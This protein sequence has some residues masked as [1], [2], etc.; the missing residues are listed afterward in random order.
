MLSDLRM[1]VEALRRALGQPS[2]TG[3]VATAL[4]EVH[5]FWSD[6]P[7]ARAPLSYAP[8][9]AVIVSGRKIGFLEDKRI[10]Y[11]P[12]QYLAIGLPLYFECETSATAAEPLLGLFLSAEPK[13]LQRLADGMADCG[14]PCLPAEPRLG[15]EPLDAGPPLLEAVTRLARQLQTPVEARLLG[16]NTLTEVFFHALQDAQGQVLLSQTRATRPEARVAALLRELDRRPPEVSDV[17]ALAE[18]A[19]MSPATF[20]RHFKAV[21]G[22]SP[23]QYQKRK[24]LM[25]A[26]NHL[27]FDGFGVAETA[28]AV[29][30]ASVAQFSRDFRAYFGTPPSRADSYPYPL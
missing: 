13:A 12:G 4:P 29:G 30:Y 20:Y 27:V 22:Y 14:P 11:G 25:K 15:V 18:A 6:R 8:G 21:T 23:R 2:E 26:K 5:L 17:N 16:P 10:A 28:R 19:G 3:F 24:R 7:V 9:I 1:A